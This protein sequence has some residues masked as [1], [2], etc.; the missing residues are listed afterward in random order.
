MRI[1]SESTVVGPRAEARIR[2][3]SPQGRVFPVDYQKESRTLVSLLRVGSLA[4]S[5]LTN[6]KTQFTNT[7]S[8]LHDRGF[9]AVCAATM[10]TWVVVPSPAAS[11]RIPSTLTWRRNH[12]LFWAWW[13]ANRPSSAADAAC[14][15]ALRACEVRAQFV[16]ACREIDCARETKTRITEVLTAIR[17]GKQPIRKAARLHSRADS[18]HPSK[19]IHR[20]R[21]RHGS[22]ISV[23]P[24]ETR[25]RGPRT[26]GEAFGMFLLRLVARL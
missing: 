21:F 2:A 11:S 4:A 8:A 15:S 10:E 19:A 16:A 24:L 25:R 13:S 1:L 18:T 23:T 9:G 12:V 20:A 14:M 3:E 26:P 22:A 6:R 5:N 7:I 17:S